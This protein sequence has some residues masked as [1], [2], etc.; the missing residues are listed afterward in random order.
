MTRF[1]GG[2]AYSAAVSRRAVAI[3]IWSAAAALALHAAGA[4]LAVAATCEEEAAEL[5]AL[6]RDEAHRAR[7]WNTA[8]GIGFGAASAGQ[9]ALA[10]TETNP[11]GA[12]DRDYEETL[13]AG[14]AKAA[15]GTLVRIVLPL[16]ATV[17]APSGEPCADVPAL[18]A[19]LADAG[20]R[21]RRAFWL[22]H[23]GG[24]ALNLGTAAL[25]AYRRSLAVGAVSFAIGYSVGLAHVYTQPRRGWRAWRERRD[26]WTVGVSV[27]GAPGRGRA[28]AWRRDGAS[29]ALG[30]GGL[31][32]LGGAAG[33]VGLG[34]VAGGGGLGGVAGDVGL[35]GG[36]GDAGLGAPAGLGAGA[37]PGAF[38]GAVVW[39]GG[40]L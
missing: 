21:E 15:L 4:G 12:F 2:L 5:R 37:A 3:G 8:W 16:R 32:G 27:M 14:A 25:L 20:R 24:T 30:G 6:V 39:V 17:P 1:A 22:S 35:G 11:F 13:Y 38:V 18:R 36:A 23:V 26:A 33:G 28:G 10:L 19:A 9:L 29:G 34:G 40:P 31:A 7:R